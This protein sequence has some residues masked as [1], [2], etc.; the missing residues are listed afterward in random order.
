M[1]S[2]ALPDGLLS[3]YFASTEARLAEE[4][5]R[6]VSVMGLPKHAGGIVACVE[7]E[8]LIKDVS[9][10]VSRGLEELMVGGAKMTVDTDGREVTGRG[11]DDKE[12]GDDQVIVSTE[13]DLEGLERMMHLLR[14]VQQGA[15][16]KPSWAQWIQVSDP[17][18]TWLIL[19]CL[20][21]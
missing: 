6:L 18:V 12:D 9:A 17:S 14:R 21:N 5:S 11:Q 15:Q 4:Q 2:S 1:R 16:V 10:L 8:L 7:E 19:S 3:V 20:T 13:P